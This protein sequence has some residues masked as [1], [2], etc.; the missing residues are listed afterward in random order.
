M[1]DYTEGNVRVPESLVALMQC[2][3]TLNGKEKE[4]YRHGIEGHSVGDPMI[5][6]R[7]IPFLET[8]FQDS[9]THAHLIY[10]N[11]IFHCDKGEETF[12]CIQHAV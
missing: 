1:T 12:R 11:Q 10:R 3:S 2:S 7:V 9:L 4:T 6:L 8:G 5:G